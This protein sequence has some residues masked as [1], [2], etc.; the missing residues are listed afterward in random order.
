MDDAVNF[1]SLFG[2]YI[3]VMEGIYSPN[4]GLPARTL[5]T[6]D[7]ELNFVIFYFYLE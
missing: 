3:Y 4:P 2:A 1:E 5:R 7:S 6:D